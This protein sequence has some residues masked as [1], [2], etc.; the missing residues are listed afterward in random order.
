MIKIVKLAIL[1]WVLPILNLDCNQ[2]NYINKCNQYGWSRLA[3]NRRPVK[4]TWQSFIT[5]EGRL[6]P[7]AQLD[8]ICEKSYLSKIFSIDRIGNENFL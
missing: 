7:I 3:Y 6:S 1:K 5:V 4:I 2:I 8:T